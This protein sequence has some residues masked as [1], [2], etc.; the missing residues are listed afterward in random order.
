[1]ARSRK[2][3]STVQFEF[4]SAADIS[5]VKSLYRR[6]RALA[7]EGAEEVVFDASRLE[8]L[9]TAGL[10]ALAVALAELREGGLRPSWAGCS[11]QLAEGARLLGLSEVLGLKP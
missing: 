10:Q 2:K 5:G 4:E 9:D 8:R 11:P 7:A 3:R 6:L 1:M